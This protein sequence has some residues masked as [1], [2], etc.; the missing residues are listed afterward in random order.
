MVYAPLRKEGSLQELM[1]KA[2]MLTRTEGAVVETTNI[3]AELLVKE[4]RDEE[5]DRIPTA[6]DRGPAR[7]ETQGGNHSTPVRVGV[8]R[9]AGRVD[10]RTMQRRTVRYNSPEEITVVAEAIIAARHVET[11]GIKPRIAL[12]RRR[13]KNQKCAL[14][15]GRSGIKQRIVQPKRRE[16]GYRRK[17]R[18]KTETYDP[19]QP[20]PE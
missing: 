6:E 15:V 8:M 2:G 18:H 14:I 10:P 9:Y 20:Q 17:N 16:L 7:I 3:T 11:F 12:A 13:R 5:T 1:H 19:G 4:T